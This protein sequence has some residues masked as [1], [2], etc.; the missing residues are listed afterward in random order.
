M[1][2]IILYG[3]ISFNENKMEN[4]LFLTY[5]EMFN[6]H[7]CIWTDFWEQL[8]GT[9]SKSQGTWIGTILTT[10]NSVLC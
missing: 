7:F 8:K 5:H 3:S 6:L 10:F 1:H 9:K 4:I 2:N